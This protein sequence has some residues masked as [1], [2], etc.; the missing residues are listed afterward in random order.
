MNYVG[1]IFTSVRD[2]Y[3]EINPATLTGA[4]DVIVVQQPDGTFLTSPFHVRFGKMG[5]LR[6]REKIVDIEIN[7]EPV[8]IHMKLGD[9]GEAFFVEEVEE[10][11]DDIPA[12]LATSPIPDETHPEDLAKEIEQ[13]TTLS[14]V[15]EN[16]CLPADFHPYSDGEMSPLECGSPQEPS[17]HLSQR[18]PT[19]L[20]DSEYEMTAK[21]DRSSEVKQDKESV[22]WSWG[23]MPHVPSHSRK[24]SQTNFPQ[25]VPEDSSLSPSQTSV[26]KQ[27]D[28]NEGRTTGEEEI[29]NMIDVAIEGP[30]EVVVVNDQST[31]APPS[32]ED[33]KDHDSN[34][35]SGGEEPASPASCDQA[36][37][38][39]SD[40]GIAPELKVKKKRKRRHYRK[41]MR[42]TSEQIEKLNLHEGPNDAVFSVT[43]AYQGTTICQ[44]Q[45]YCWNYDDKIVISDIDGTITKS[46]VL[47]HILPILGRDWA[48]SGVTQL[49]TKIYDNG[50]KLI[51]LSA[52]A[53]GQAGTTREY[54]RSVR[55]GD[56]FLP[57]GPLLLNPTSLFNALHREVIEKKPEDFKIS[58]LKDIQALFPTNPFYAGFGNKINDTWAY[59]AVNI[60][61]SRIFTINH[62]GELK[63][64][65]IQT[66]Q[67]SY[68]R[69][70][71]VV[72]QMFPPLEYTSAKVDFLPEYSSFN[73]WRD[74]IAELNEDEDELVKALLVCGFS[75]LPTA[76]QGKA[77]SPK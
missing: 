72:D 32:T 15:D 77:S 18:P 26:I 68:T 42:L 48:Q 19:P 61:L 63:L 54:L 21:D 57:D 74:P 55:Q 24:P 6:H 27:S 35:C 65:L 1:R 8:D 51:Y 28:A 17:K 62:K 29:A 76:S 47:G 75:K 70:S 34:Y 10:E 40:P 69:L 12:S 9:S 60:P 25:S 36:Q 20:S 44:C 7:G 45:I 53:I 73:Y 50:Y 33:K 23:K 13:L 49:F 14:Q 66:F 31:V 4:I 39:T 46:D 56:V 5:V 3:R 22:S 71:D 16:N 41:N 58:C 11:V 52:R 67:S 38:P 37:S 59:R 2:F 30:D 64:E 43:T